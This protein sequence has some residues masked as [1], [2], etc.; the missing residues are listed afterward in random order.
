MF[1]AIKYLLKRGGIENNDESIDS[2]FENG[3]SFPQLIATIFQV[4]QI[5]NITKTPHSEYFKSKNNK[6]AL[7]FLFDKNSTIAELNPNF[8]TEND[9]IN[10]IN[11]IITRQCFK[12]N[13]EDIIL[14]CKK[15]LKSSDIKCESLDDIMKPTFL[16]TLL[17][18]LTDDSITKDI[19]LDKGNFDIIINS[20]E[21]AKVPLILNQDSF[22]IENPDIYLIQIQIIFDIFS[23]K[24]KTFFREAN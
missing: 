5:P 22:N 3:Y 12:I 21:K 13:S 7:Q 9:R 15:L 20:F 11:L 2:F 23:E 4:D 17:S 14:Q 8:Q 19:N 18:V 24:I 16:T 10:L 1:A 6:V